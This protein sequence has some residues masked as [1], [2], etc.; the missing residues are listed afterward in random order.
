MSTTEQEYDYEEGGW[1]VSA[2][3]EGPRF[4][5]LVYALGQI[6]D[7]CVFHIEPGRIHT[8]PVDPANVSK[9]CVEVSASGI[10]GQ[11]DVGVSIAQLYDYIR[12]DR[13]PTYR[14]YFE[15]D[16]DNLN[17]EGA[18]SDE[19]VRT[20]S[21]ASVRSEG[22]TPEVTYEQVCSP[23]NYKFKGVVGSVAEA[24]SDADSRWNGIL[25]D[26]SDGELSVSAHRSERAGGCSYEWSFTTDVS[27]GEA[28]L[29]SAD[30]LDDIVSGIPANEEL[31]VSF[32]RDQPMKI[33]VGGW[34]T[35]YLAARIRQ[36]E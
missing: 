3:V 13:G 21:P 34:L 2:D 6:V 23:E 18:H 19:D 25:L 4:R 20:F 24:V 27:E 16:D 8:A 1:T 35:Y 33:E 26:P 9:A 5:K 10:D 12:Y 22:D 28:A 30:Y 7:E 11:V 29:F 15:P 17:I 14:L 32:G 31:I 36:E